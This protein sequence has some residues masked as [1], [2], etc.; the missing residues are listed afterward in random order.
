MKLLSPLLELSDF[1]TVLRISPVRSKRDLGGTCQ[2]G[3][4]LALGLAARQPPGLLERTTLSPD[5]GLNVCD[6]FHE[7]HAS[8]LL[9]S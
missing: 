5:S 1:P 7:E 9:P 2:P 8:L 3:F 6:F 4:Q